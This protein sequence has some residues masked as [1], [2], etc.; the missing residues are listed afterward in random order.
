[1]HK[2][3]LHF[4]SQAII[5]PLGSLPELRKRLYVAFAYLEVL[6]D[7]TY[8]HYDVSPRRKAA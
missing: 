1:M 6:G 7:V 5:V 2:A 4:K 8:D 3:I